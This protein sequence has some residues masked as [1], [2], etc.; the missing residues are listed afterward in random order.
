MTSPWQRSLILG[1]VGA[2][3]SLW[4]LEN[5]THTLGDWLPAIVIGS[6]IAWVVLKFQ[7]SDTPK[8][9]VEPVSLNK[10]QTELVE[11]KGLLDQLAIESQDLS[12]DG[13]AQQLSDLRSQ[14]Q[15]ITADLK[16]DEIR[17]AVMGGKSV[18]KTM[19]MNL[20]EIKW[21]RGI[22]QKLVLQDTPELFAATEGGIIAER[23]AWKLARS[24]DVILF[25]T[26]GDLTATEFQAIQKITSV[27]KRLVLV[28]NKQDQYLPEE[29]KIVLEQL[30]ER[31]DGILSPQDVIGIAT[32]PKSL[33]IRQHRSDG[34]FKEWMEKVEP[35]I[36]PLLER[37]NQIL[38]QEG[39]QLVLSSSL[40]NVTAVQ[41]EAKSALNRIR[42][43][44]AMPR[45]DQ[46]QWIVAGTAFA[47]P[48]PALDL[49][50]TAAIN[51]QMVMDLSNLYQR[52]FTLEQAKT[53]AATMAGVMVKLGLVEVSTQAIAAIMKTNAI[54]FVAG[55][56]IQGVSAAYLTR[57]AGLTLIE[58]F[59]GESAEEIKPDIL[60]QIMEK[61]FEQN[62]RLPFMQMFVKQAVDRLVKTPLSASAPVPTPT[63]LDG[64][65]AP[66]E[67]PLEIGAKLEKD[68][69]SEIAKS[70]EPKLLEIPE[71]SLVEIN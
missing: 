9:R 55:G 49:L 70:D 42:R 31:V 43:D 10:V 12:I 62:R 11:A 33:K 20:L 68:V 47:N 59:E 45:I 19:L 17:F 53:V 15:N 51:G 44:R 16:R 58:Y 32:N 40:S 36:L 52:K 37:L 28:F 2:T 41:A 3:L 65:P 7:Q 38:I 24:A 22:S 56:L 64:L 57:L 26:T 4:V 25:M 23:D 34:T 69:N 71:V 61:V 8:I 27:G 50:A 54:T 13:S 67:A 21:A 5:L 14:I 29:Q 30:R 63:P 1:G 48:F 39:K 18:G 6:G 60:Q 66:Q 46:A 35:Q